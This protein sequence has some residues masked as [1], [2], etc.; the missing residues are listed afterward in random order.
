MN[1]AVRRAVGFALQA[2]FAN[3]TV[4]ADERGQHIA[5]AEA[6]EAIDHADLVGWRR[7]TTDP[8]KV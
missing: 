1:T 4:T 3:G 6:A 7:R 8:G 2:R 5:G